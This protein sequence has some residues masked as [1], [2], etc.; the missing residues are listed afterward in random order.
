V[1][2]AQLLEP[3]RGL[4]GACE[5]ESA[6]MLTSDMSLTITATRLPSR[7]LRM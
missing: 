1:G 3:A 7:L 5:V 4:G 2:A 6:S